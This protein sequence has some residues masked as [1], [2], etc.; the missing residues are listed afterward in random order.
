LQVLGN[1]PKTVN[2]IKNL[3][4]GNVKRPGSSDDLNLQGKSFSR[5]ATVA[6]ILL[7]LSG[8]KGKFG[9]ILV[10]TLESTSFNGF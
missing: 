8:H 4:W 6:A 10:N 7:V 3:T 5:K 2:N 1:N 9:N